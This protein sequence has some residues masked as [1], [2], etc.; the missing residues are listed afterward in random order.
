MTR[1]RILV[2]DDEVRVLASLRRGLELSD[3]E[4]ITAGAQ[5]SKS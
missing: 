2:V 5:A 4:V 1:Q 3:F